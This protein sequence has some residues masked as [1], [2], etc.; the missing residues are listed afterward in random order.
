MSNK[1]WIE[2]IIRL[3]GNKNHKLKKQFIIEDELYTEII[4]NEYEPVDGHYR[5]AIVSDNYETSLN[6][7]TNRELVRLFKC[8]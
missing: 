6:D 4:F 1:Y 3:I 2:R 5:Y 7:L 8:L